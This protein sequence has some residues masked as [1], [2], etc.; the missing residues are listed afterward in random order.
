MSVFYHVMSRG[1][2]KRTIF[3]EDRDYLR[4]IHDL[5]VFNDANPNCNANIRFNRNRHLESTDI[6]SQYIIREP[7]DLIVDLH[8]FCI[9]SN[10]YHLLVSPIKEN[11]LSQFLQKLNIGYAKYFNIKYER[12]GALFESRF[13]RIEINSEPHF[14]HLPYYIHSNPLNLFDYGWRT[15]EITDPQKAWEFLMNYRW[16]SHLDYA[17]KKNF[18]LVTRREFLTEIFNGPDSYQVTFRQW[19]EEMEMPSND[20]TLE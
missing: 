7:R 4:F 14:I 6:A 12:K 15:R 20:V 9:M 3:E 8:A 2:D 18:P 5:F 13:K 17:G 1:V 10:H 19:I 16:S 11:G